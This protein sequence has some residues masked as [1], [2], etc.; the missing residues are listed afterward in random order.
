MNIALVFALLG[1]FSTLTGFCTYFSKMKKNSAPKIPLGVAAGLLV[2]L[3]LGAHAISLSGGLSLLLKT[4]IVIPF[5]FTLLLGSVFTF[6]LLQKK[7]PLNEIKVDLGDSFLPFSSTDTGGQ[8]FSTNDL[9]GQRVLLKFYRGSWCP[10]CSAELKMFNEMQDDFSEFGVRIIALSGDTIEQAEAHIKRE[11]LSMTLLSDPQLIV[12]KQY[13]V[14]HHK[15]LS[16]DS[17]NVK[18]IFGIGLPFGKAS[19]RSIAIP[20]S[21]LIDEHGVIQWI[22]QSDDYRLR[23]SRDNIM[24]A[25]QKAF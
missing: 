9:K 21:L 3:I 6:L 8:P 17:S 14:E 2:G 22:D 15:A 5:I 23:A 10:Y 12:I 1:L 18:T 13:G 25:L 4:A 7:P 11:N 24:S 20:T 16:L 19:Y